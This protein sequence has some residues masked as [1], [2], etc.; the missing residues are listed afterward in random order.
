MDVVLTEDGR[1]RLQERLNRLDQDVLP[2]LREQLWGPDRDGRIDGALELALDER[3]RLSDA[4]AA[5]RVAE[6]L[7][8][9]P[10]VVEIGDWV[11]VKAEDGSREVFRIVDPIEAP[12]DST[13]ISY[14][15]P[16]AQILLGRRTGDEVELRTRFAPPYRYVIVETHR[17]SPPTAA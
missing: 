12:L 4:L 17:A 14:E 9:D 15:S 8:D 11:T 5:G 7:A 6:N 13:R 16:L 2:S 1:K 10:D 3:R